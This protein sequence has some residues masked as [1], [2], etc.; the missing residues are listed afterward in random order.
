[1]V[2]CGSFTFQHPHTVP[3]TT[4]NTQMSS[5]ALAQGI[6]YGC[7]KNCLTISQSITTYIILFISPSE[8]SSKVKMKSCEVV[9]HKKECAEQK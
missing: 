6:F 8:R 5:A 2:S 7:L 1:M 4:S 3:I 9:E